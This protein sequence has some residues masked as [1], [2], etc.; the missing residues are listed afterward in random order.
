MKSKYTLPLNEVGIHAQAADI[1]FTLALLDGIWFYQATETCYDLKPESEF[2]TFHCTMTTIQAA[3]L[4]FLFINADDSIT[5]DMAKNMYAVIEPAL[6]DCP[7][8]CRPIP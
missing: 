8:E 5:E 7:K 3:T 1:E 6:I 4:M 2:V